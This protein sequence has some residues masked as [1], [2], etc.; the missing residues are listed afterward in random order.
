[1]YSTNLSKSLYEQVKEPYPSAHPLNAGNRPL[2]FIHNDVDT[3]IS[4]MK[5][6]GAIDGCIS[7]SICKVIFNAVNTIQMAVFIFYKTCNVGIKSIHI[8]LFYSMQTVFGSENKMIEM[9]TVT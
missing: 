8:I 7:V 2:L 6:I 1:M 9:L 5:S 4:L 3:L